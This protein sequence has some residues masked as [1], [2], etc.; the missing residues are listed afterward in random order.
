M[1]INSR[2][3]RTIVFATA[4]IVASHLWWSQYAHACSEGDRTALK[5]AGF[6]A[7]AVEQICTSRPTYMESEL[8]LTPTQV[9]NVISALKAKGCENVAVIPQANAESRAV[10]SGKGS[11]GSPANH[12]YM[13]VA[14]NCT[15]VARGYACPLGSDVQTSAEGVISEMQMD[16]CALKNGM[17]GSEQLS[18]FSP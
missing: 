13:L 11:A 7:C 3:I 9:P 6:G 16:I 1:E 15:L 8:Q 2:I 10:A 5:S 4:A 17:K 14:K 18:S 12:Y